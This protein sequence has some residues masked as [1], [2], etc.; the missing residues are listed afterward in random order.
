MP[1]NHLHQDNSYAVHAKA[2]LSY[3][4][5]LL[6]H[7]RV[8]I[9]G[10]N[11]ELVKFIVDCRARFVTAVAEK[12]PAT[13]WPDR[14][15]AP[16]QELQVMSYEDLRFRDGSY[17]LV[18]IADLTEIA[19]LASALNEVRRVI[20][21]RGHA[22][23]AVPNS[24]CDRRLGPGPQVR[25]PD[26][27]EVYDALAA[28]FPSVQMIGQSPFVGYAV[29]DLS[30]EA[31]DLAISLDSGL[32]GDEAEEIEWFLAVCG[33]HP[34]ALDP[35]AIIQVPLADA[36]M[37]EA[38]EAALAAAKTEVE[39]L[40]ATCDQME[41][42]RRALDDA[43]SSERAEVSALRE[44]KE[45]VTSLDA[46]LKEAKLELGN[47]GVRIE[48][49]E[50]QLEEECLQSEAARERGVLLAKELDNERK[51]AQKKQLEEEF[52]RRSADM[53]LQSKARESAV[54]LKQAE[55]RARSA[56]AARDELVERMR[57]DASELD[58]LREQHDAHATELKQV[59][60]REKTLQ[61]E[62]RVL[63]QKEA[64]AGSRASEM[65]SE[66]KEIRGQLDAVNE[67]RAGF[68]KETA[69]LEARLSTAAADLGRTQE[70]VVRLE[71]IVRDLVV[72]LERCDIA[73][74]ELVAKIDQLEGE[75]AGLLGSQLGHQRAR[76]EANLALEAAEKMLETNRQD[77]GRLAADLDQAREDR[78]ALV[79]QI[80]DNRNQE[81]A[82]DAEIHQRD[83]QI[84]K[85]EGELKAERWQTAELRARYEDAIQRQQDAA[86]R[87]TGEQER[88]KRL[89]EELDVVNG[90]LGLERERAQALEKD[91]ADAQAQVTAA[92]QDLDQERNARKKT[93]A[94]LIRA[95]AQVTS[96]EAELSRVRDHVEELTVARDASGVLSGQLDEER[97]HREA[98]QEEISTCNAR[99]EALTAV[100]DTL[101]EKCA[102]L[103]S[104]NEAAEQQVAALEQQLAAEERTAR[105]VEDE[106]E[107]QTAR[108]QELS[109]DLTKARDRIEALE[110]EVTAAATERT[111][112]ENEL[113]ELELRMADSTKRI[114]ETEEATDEAIRRSNNAEAKLEATQTEL[115]GTCAE[116]ASLKVTE[117]DIQKQVRRE[118]AEELKE[119]N[120]LAERVSDLEA[121]LHQSEKSLEEQVSRNDGMA[122]AMQVLRAELADESNRT[123]LAGADAARVTGEAND[124]RQ[125]LVAKEEALAEQMAQQDAN[126]RALVALRNE[127]ALLSNK[128]Q[129]VREAWLKEQQRSMDLSEK[130]AELE[131]RKE[132]MAT[133]GASLVEM[134]KHAAEVSELLAA[135]R[136]QIKV[137]GAELTSEKERVHSMEDSISE[138]RKNAQSCEVA[139]SEAK[140]RA[141]L[142]EREHEESIRSRQHLES[143]LHQLKE[144]LSVTRNAMNEAKVKISTLNSVTAELSD[145]KAT[146]ATAQQALASTQEA[147]ASA[148]QKS[149]NKVPGEDA[150]REIAALKEEIEA[151]QKERVVEDKRYEDQAALLTSVTAQLEERETRATRL[152]RELR[153]LKGQIGEHESDIAAWEME[154][155]FR[156]SR[157]SQLESENTALQKTLAEKENNSA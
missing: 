109:D 37:S 58:R 51:A 62:A 79:K 66:L 119:A 18:I 122:A 157:I 48:S 78:D 130:V 106:A 156:D 56:E 54:K 86:T 16:S 36:T 135:A 14:E 140:E 33:E 153:D 40:R 35:Y 22:V 28:V 93:D 97:R 71:A 53:D 10:D 88:A 34:A 75:K 89:G 23:V 3:V 4:Q 57:E 90:Q 44:V 64:A 2:R 15:S 111:R 152:E 27:Y 87:L 141:S 129:H 69:D 49:L 67:E 120:N 105:R 13:P 96:L 17:D 61:D 31:P 12:Q 6:A 52:A 46:E 144:E 121:Q 100:E 45:A 70:E 85:L 38:D 24:V 63:A 74:A 25:P 76:L 1:A 102:A 92:A 113:S 114:S 151:I 26:Y 150:L 30:F 41:T 72:D 32:V 155:K 138:M 149:E 8:L 136:E 82:R 110:N 7:R 59:R 91:L 137:V 11:F 101:K 123:R 39:S 19:S 65:Q 132:E 127:V 29:A 84:A 115:M 131:A 50:K 139:L 118:L 154:L 108:A 47:R 83:L 77:A 148:T 126:E 81:A 94:A 133:S 112:L 73:D 107:R 99:I 147:L 146:L 21:P 43:L 60:E 98:L 124:L 42:E 143:Q 128:M 95:T 80:E 145:T 55:E 20:G 134:E 5:G 116:L 68:E 142:A 103:A 117:A 125:R 9:L 104:D